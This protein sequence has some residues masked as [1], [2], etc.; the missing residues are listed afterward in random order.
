MSDNESDSIELAT[1]KEKKK[2]NVTK[3]IAKDEGKVETKRKFKVIH[4]VEEVE[5]HVHSAEVR[6]QREKYEVNEKLAAHEKMRDAR[7]A[8][9]NPNEA[10]TKLENHIFEV[11]NTDRRDLNTIV[12][13]PCIDQPGL[14]VKMIDSKDDFNAMFK[15]KK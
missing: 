14:K 12:I 10:K 1:Q 11:R 6:A 4:T 13:K 9:K 15:N 3:E 2:I 5:N 8:N 7:K